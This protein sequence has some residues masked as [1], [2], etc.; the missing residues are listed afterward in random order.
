MGSKRREKT[1]RAVRLGVRAARVGKEYRRSVE[2]EQDAQGLGEGVGVVGFGRGGAIWGKALARVVGSGENVSTIL[3][4]QEP[5]Q[6][7]SAAIGSNAT[8]NS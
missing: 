4:M 5:C 1:K 3:S 2:A 7:L 6:I 8:F